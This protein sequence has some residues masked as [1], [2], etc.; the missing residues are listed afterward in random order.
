MGRNW[1]LISDGHAFLK[2]LCVSVPAFLDFSFAFRIQ[3][4]H[5]RVFQRVIIHIIDQEVLDW[6][7]FFFMPFTL[8][9]C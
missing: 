8:V 5:L 4:F 6:V 9:S 3:F 7:P 2:C 1:S